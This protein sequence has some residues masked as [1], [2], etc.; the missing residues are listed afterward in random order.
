VCLKAPNKG[1]LR[2]FGPPV[3]QR[4]Y[5]KTQQYILGIESVLGHSGIT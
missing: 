5:K 4:D 1:H 3:S 2:A